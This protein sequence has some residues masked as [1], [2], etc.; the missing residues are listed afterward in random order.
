MLRGMPRTGYLRYWE[1]LRGTKRVSARILSEA[2]V[3]FLSVELGTLELWRDVPQ[4][5]EG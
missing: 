5:E 4:F 3:G 2:K 1:E